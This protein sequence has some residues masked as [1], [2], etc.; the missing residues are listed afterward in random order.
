M[1]RERIARLA[2]RAYPLKVRDASGA[3]MLG[4][5]LD[6]SEGSTAVLLR[7][8]FA[9]TLAGLRSRARTTAAV[10]VRRLAADACCRAAT[11]W[12][13]LILGFTVPLIIVSP[14]VQPG[15]WLNA[16]VLAPLALALLGCDRLAGACGLA[17]TVLLLTLTPTPDRL[18]TTLLV[19]RLVPVVCY[20]AMVIAPRRRPIDPRRLLWLAATIAIAATATLAYGHGPAG[21]NRHGADIAEAVLVT[22]SIIG[23]ARLPTDPRLAITCAIIWTDIGLAYQP[24]TPQFAS[25]TRRSINTTRSHSQRTPPAIR[26]TTSHRV[27]PPT[28]PR[29]RSSQSEPCLRVR[30]GVRRLRLVAPCVRKQPRSGPVLTAPS[31]R[32]QMLLARIY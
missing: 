11:L 21:L 13:L 28:A 7:E 30:E 5:L 27:T 26:E 3:E 16:V 19:E 23:F 8:S 2:V 25:V 17:W 29:G 12:G 14:A 9:L 24:W 1:T 6:L 31:W 18:T 10:G 15:V 20:L 22:L 32:R 4:T